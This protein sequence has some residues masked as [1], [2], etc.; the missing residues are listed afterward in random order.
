MNPAKKVLTLSLKVGAGHLRAA[1]AAECAIREQYENSESTHFDVLEYTTPFYRRVFTSLYGAMIERFPLAW[2]MVYEQTRR[3][4][5]TGYSKRAAAW[6]TGR[7]S[8]RLMSAITEYA[9]D[10]ILCTHFTAAEAVA[11]A[12]RRQQ[13]QVP[14]CVVLTDYDLH[15]AWLHRGVDCYC[16]ATE[17]MAT[18]LRRLELFGA[19]VHVT[20]IPIHPLFAQEY[21]HRPEMRTQL[22]LNPGA[23]TVLLTGGGCGLGT[24]NE[25]ARLLLQN[26]PTVQIVAVAGN[27]ERMR[28]LLE[29][30]AAE[31]PRLI[32][33][34]YVNNM[35]DYMAASDLI[36]T[37]PGGLTSSEC[38]A[39]G[40]PAVISKPIPGQEEHNC[41]FLIENQVA[42]RA[43]NTSELLV[44]VRALIEDEGLRHY[45]SSRARS[46]AKRRAAY[47]VAEIVWNLM[48]NAE[49]QTRASATAPSASAKV[50][51]ALLERKAAV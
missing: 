50:T 28:T 16:V 36:V 43:R 1:Q 39:M 27:N 5:L 49:A 35:H 24:L 46:L 8:L 12:R 19:A 47:S 7:N 17:Q 33:K 40:L 44:S 2:K 9:P 10:A 31:F 29:Q 23:P 37:K 13:L 51:P 26:F 42:L 48:S 34:G 22:K 6:L 14:V 45:M 3:Q 25:T 11:L 21:P 38:L 15:S 30:V 41:E 18:D 4:K 20:G 32:V